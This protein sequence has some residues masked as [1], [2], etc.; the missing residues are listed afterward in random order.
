MK[1]SEQDAVLYW[2]L[3][4]ELLFF[5]NQKKKLCADL[6]TVKDFIDLSQADKMTTR[7]ALY[8]DID[9]INTFIREKPGNL[10]GEELEIVEKWRHFVK[11]NFY[12]ERYL[13]NHAI[14]ISDR[15][16]YAVQ[17][18]NSSFDEMIPR[19]RLPHAVEAVLLPFKGKIIYDGILPGYNLFFGG[20]IK[21]RIKE[22]Y[23]AAKQADRIIDNLEPEAKSAKASKREKPL[24]DW[25]PE[26]EDLIQKAKKLKG[27][28]DQPPFNAP[29]FSL[30]KAT[31]DLSFKAVEKPD[32]L[33]ELWE[34]YNKVTRV[35]RKIQTIFD[36][37][38]RYRD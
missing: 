12:I 20:G 36:R 35:I 25:K 19:Q 33:D 16:V 27:G 26:I 3:M 6:D 31:L 37:A 15:G 23:M 11:D 21:R 14:F 10:S 7:E 4:W 9:L 1:L 24:K 29:I 30:I 5:V 32:D 13:K 34:G 22:D 38:E 8:G 28:A 17:A 2:K 18:I